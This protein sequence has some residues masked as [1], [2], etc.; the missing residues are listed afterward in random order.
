MRL[1]MK[2]SQMPES[3]ATLPSFSA[4]AK[5][6]AR[7]TSEVDGV[8][9]TSRSF[10]TW[11]GLKKCRP[12]MRPGIFRTLGNLQRIEVGGVGG[13]RHLGADHGGEVPENHALDLQILEH[14]LDH[15]IR[16]RGLLRSTLSRSSRARR[17]RRVL[18]RH[19]AAFDGAVE[20]AGDA[21]SGGFGAGGILFDQR[22]GTASA[23]ARGGDA[24]SHEAAADDRDALHG[25]GATEGLAPIGIL[26]ACSAAAT[27]LRAG[28]RFPRSCPID[29]IIKHTFAHLGPRVLAQNER[30][31]KIAAS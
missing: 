22:D 27:C 24:A 7:V 16:R 11:A 31:V 23:Q 28:L 17:C 6:V 12:R 21:L 3:T 9:T 26:D 25:P 29:V 19:L 18:G 13:D 1:P 30:D 14:R 2:P 10:M 20:Q 8:F 4:K 15:K 5:A